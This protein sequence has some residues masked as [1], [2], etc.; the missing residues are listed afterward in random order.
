MSQWIRDNV[1]TLVIVL[2][3]VG[4]AWGMVALQCKQIDAKADKETVYRELDH[5]RESLARIENKL[6]EI[7][8]DH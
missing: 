3:G 8:R 4:S 6:D 5:V 7:A 1:I 2:F